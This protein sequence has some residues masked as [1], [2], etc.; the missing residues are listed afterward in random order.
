MNIAE[1]IATYIDAQGIL[2]YNPSGTD[3]EIYFDNQPE[4]GSVLTLYNSK[5]SYSKT[6]LG[7]KRVGML[8]IYKGTNNPVAS[9]D[10]ANE[11]FEALQ[12]LNGYFVS[13]QNYIVS[14]ISNDGGPGRLG[15]DK[16]A[17]YEYGMNFVIEFKKEV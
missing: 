8:I 13:G 17:N 11:V 1:Q 15:V 4:K 14:C 16:K 3:S 12:G 10:K 2:N 6:T 7:Y 5:G 9:Y